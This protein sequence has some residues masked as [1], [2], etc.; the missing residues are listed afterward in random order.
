[1][2]K[3]GCSAKTMAIPAIVLWAACFARAAQPVE[4]IIVRFPQEGATLPTLTAV[5]VMGEVSSPKARFSING[6]PVKPYRTGGFLAYVPVSTGTF[7]LECQ[8]ELAAGTKTL[9]RA[10]AVAA[11]PEPLPAGPPF[12][13][14]PS[15]EPSSDLELTPGDWLL[16]QFRGT[17][18]YAAEFRTAGGKRKFPMA[19]TSP[20][21]YQGAAQVAAEDFPVLGPVRFQLSEDRGRKT[22]ALSPGKVAV[23]AGPSVVSV[24]SEEAV[25]VRSGPGAGYIMFPPAGT[26]FLLAGRA[27][28]QA[29]LSLAPGF[30]GWVEAEK[31]EVLPPGTPPPHARLRS[32]RT[33]AGAGSSHVRLELTDKIPFIVEPGKDLD[34]LTVRLFYASADTDWV[35]YDS[36]ETLVREVSWRVPGSGAVEVTVSLKDAGRLW[37]YGVSWDDGALK[38]ELRHPPRLAAYGSVFVGRS[39]V[40]DPGHGPSSP[41]AVGPTGLLEEEANSAITRQL[42]RML[43]SEGASVRLTRG[44]GADASL[45]ER[46]RIARSEQPDLFVS[47]HNNNLNEG[48]NP[49]IYP[50][51]YSVFY[52]HPHSMDLARRI[53]RSFQRSIKL[54]DER[55]RFGDLFMARISEM[56]SVLVEGAYMTYPEQE[57]MLRR[58]AFQ[59]SMASAVLEGMRDF[60]QA[61]RRR[62]APSGE[63]KTPVKR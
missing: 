58:P 60:L 13:D 6:K 22:S 43:K 56:P 63:R 37:G 40:L 18:G 34:S 29:R 12:I 50:H 25:S 62:Q 39:V 45:A 19:E 23:L 14:E 8:L 11:R 31:L 48:A 52:Y 42:E 15:A 24:K 47:I 21:F 2:T 26:R 32:V 44:S 17:S 51:G 35:V 49:F 57:E 16:P 1:M 59:R 30:D 7:A 61:E 53:H 41:G 33:E 10:V 54:A 9:T 38:I 3:Q 55:L 46:A 20:G 27:G 5:Y 36:S 4:P 28:R